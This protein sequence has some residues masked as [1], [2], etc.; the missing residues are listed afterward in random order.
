M[1]RST[2]GRTGQGLLGRVLR[3]GGLAAAAVALAAALAWGGGGL[4]TVLAVGP[5][6]ACPGTTAC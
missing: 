5:G 1:R 4:G 3:T 6:P 2:T